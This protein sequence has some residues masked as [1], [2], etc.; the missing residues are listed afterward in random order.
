MNLLLEAPTAVPYFTDVGATL[1]ALGVR[2]SEFDWYVS[3]I[4][5]NVYIDGLSQLDG[6]VAG[7]Q[8]DAALSH[9]GLQFIWGVFSAFP[10]GMRVEVARPPA[11]DGNSRYWRDAD[12]LGPQLQGALFELCCWDSSATILIGITPEQARSYMSAY[13]QAKP[14]GE[15]LRQRP[16]TP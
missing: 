5:T 2:A 15:A 9:T 6:W 11:A 12:T 14:L 7:L 13:P 16:V 3:D 8:L 1:Y 4:E 10:P